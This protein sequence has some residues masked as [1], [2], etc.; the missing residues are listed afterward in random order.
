MSV[1]LECSHHFIQSLG[2]IGDVQIGRALI[3]LSLETRVE[4]LLPTRQY[5]SSRVHGSTNSSKAN[6][7]SEA[8][9]PLDAQLRVSN[10]AKFGET[11]SEKVS[12]VSLQILQE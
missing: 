8:M 5:H 7:V 9:K 12:E 2:Q 10:V 1:G 4:R 3:A 11:K 6:L